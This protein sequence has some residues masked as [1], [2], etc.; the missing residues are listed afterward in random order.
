MHSQLQNLSPRHAAAVSIVT[1]L[2]G[3]VYLAALNAIAG[4]SSRP[5]GLVLQVVFYNAVWFSLAEGA[6]VLSVFRPG[7]SH[8]LLKWSLDV[9]RRHRR[10]IVVVFFVTLGAYLVIDGIVELLGI[11]Q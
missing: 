10:T 7:V 11:Q 5:T 9:A 1:H 8:D 2:P 4:S 6:L 3:L